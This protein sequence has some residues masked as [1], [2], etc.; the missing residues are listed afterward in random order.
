MNASDDRP[1]LDAVLN[2]WERANAVLLNLLRAI[3]RDRLD[4]RAMDGSPT[5]AEMF[6]HMHHERMISVF[7]NAPEHAG[8]VPTREWDPEP[9]PERI[10]G[11]LLESGRRVRAA[12]E[13]RTT[14]GRSLD[15]E[16]AHPIHLIQFLTFHEGYH[17]GQIKLALKAA[18][19]PM[20]D[21]EA[22]PLT[23][24]VWRTR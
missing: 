15:R 5:V 13:G 21:A 12:V 24:R 11:L 3:P 2:G 6:T 14:A 23:W 9:D 18:G 19:A 7:E 16:F 8:P 10:A 4:A 22:G 1:L 17:H 20:P